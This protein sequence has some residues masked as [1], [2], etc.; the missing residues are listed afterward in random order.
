[1]RLLLGFAL[2]FGGAGFFILIGLPLPWFLGSLTA[3]IIA[4]VAGVAFERPQQLSVGMRAILGVAVGAAFTPELFARFAD[5]TLSLAMLLPFMVAVIGLGMIYFE[6][7]AGYNRPTAF[8]CAVPGGLTDMVTMA[9]DA[10]ANPRTVTLIQATRIVLIVFLLPFWLQWVGGKTIGIFVPG[11]LHINQMLLVDALMLGALG[12]IGW[13]VAS[14]MGL[15]GAPLVGPMI[16]SGIAH[17]LGLT[18]AKIPQEILI[19]A[20]ITLGILL[21]AQFRGLTWREFSSTMLWGSGLF[22]LPRDRHGTDR[23]DGVAAHR[24][25]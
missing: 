11:A 5:M 3:C 25:R 19:F 17:A 16:V 1:M 24:L 21:G 18:T 6:R 2:G 10:G 7:I 4:S 9:E 12:W 20:Q 15:A 13:K 14:G 8:F 22:A 23:V